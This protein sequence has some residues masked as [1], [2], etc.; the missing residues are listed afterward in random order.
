MVILLWNTKDTLQHTHEGELWGPFKS[1]DSDLY[2]T[3]GY[4]S[5]KLLYLQHNGVGDTL[6]Y[7]DSD[8]LSMSY[9]M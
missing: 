4:F 2:P 1:S 5:G 3:F 8:I 7:Q 9:H 6:V